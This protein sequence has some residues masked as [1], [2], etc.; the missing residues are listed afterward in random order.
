MKLLV[1]THTFP[2]SKHSNAKRP[3]YLVRAFLD[4]GWEVDVVTS[5]IGVESDQP[6]VIEHPNLNII[7]DG[8][9]VW[10]LQGKL[11]KMRLGGLA[12]ILGF[13]ANGLL[14]PDFCAIWARKIFRRIKKEGRSHDRV[15]AFVFPPSVLL[16]GSYGVVDRRWVFD[17]QES[18]TPQFDRFSR[19]SVLQRMMLGRLKRMERD[20]LHDAGTVVFT[21]D[22]NRLAY[23][24]RGLVPAER[25]KHLPYFYDEAA[26]RSPARISGRFEIGYYGNFDLTGARSPEIFLKSLAGF[27][28]RFPEAREATRFV[29]YG[30]W[31]ARHDSF[32]NELEL[33]DV[34]EINAAVPYDQYLKRLQTSPVL[35]LIVAKEHNLFMPSKIVD[36][37]GSRRP[38]LAFVPEGSEMGGVL[39]S[40]GM[41]QYSCESDDVTQGRDAISRLWAAHQEGKLIVDEEKTSGWSSA[42]LIPKYFQILEGSPE[43]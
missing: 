10:R 28:R 14:F 42:A 43:D 7:R 22:S 35:L 40:A 2:P 39:E 17:F 3:H 23:V 36:Y 25:T 26:F 4:A 34:C 20:T 24:E 33:G 16:S 18:V 37:F 31:L 21:A 19:K 1:I 32:V 8:D 27:L 5:F 13:A 6:E 29:F 30:A 9:P 41:G 12:K 11:R 15:L 38:I